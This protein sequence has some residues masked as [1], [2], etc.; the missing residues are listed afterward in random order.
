MWN[1]KKMDKE[2]I[3]IWTIEPNFRRKKN[4]KDSNMKQKSKHDKE[5]PGIRNEDTKIKET[6]KIQRQE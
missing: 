4:D 3:G 1:K 6:G 5:K 2:K